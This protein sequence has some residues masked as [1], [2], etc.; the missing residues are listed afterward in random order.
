MD[1][2]DC[3]GWMTKQLIGYFAITTAIVPSRQTLIEP[4]CPPMAQGNSVDSQLKF[5]KS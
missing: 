2:P 4:C 3:F 5:E 1:S